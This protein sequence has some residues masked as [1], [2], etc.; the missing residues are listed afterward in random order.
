MPITLM[1]ERSVVPG[2]QGEV[3]RLLRQLRSRATQQDG[4]ISGQTVVDAF[5]PGIFMT[6]SIWSSMAAWERWKS[7]PERIEIVERMND[8]LQGPPK[9]RIWLQDEDAPP[10]A[11]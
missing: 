8:V 3:K 6:I 11:I 1:V 2:A 4:F 7:S 5:N 10:A 9:P